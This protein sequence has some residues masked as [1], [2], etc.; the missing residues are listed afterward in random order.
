MPSPDTN[1]FPRLER[2]SSLRI[3]AALGWAEIGGN[4]RRSLL[5]IFSISLGIASVVTMNSLMEGN[6]IEVAKSLAQMG[7]LDIV[8]V[9]ANQARTVDQEL[10][11]SK[12]PGLRYTDL[13]ALQDHDP[14]IEMLLPEE[15]SSV[16]EIRGPK[17]VHQAWAA[18]VN[19]GQFTYFG[20]NFRTVGTREGTALRWERGA[21]ICLLGEQLASEIFGN[22]EAALG[23]VLEHDGMKLKVEGLIRP[24]GRFDW[25]GQVCYFPYA[26]Q[27][28]RSPAALANLSEIK[29]KL[30][31]GA[32]LKG[33]V[34]GIRKHLLRQHR[35]IEDFSVRTAEEQIGAAQKS[36]R[37]IKIVGNVIASLSL[38]V[39]A[40]GILNLMLAT[41]SSRLRELGVRKAL[42][43]GNLNILAQFISESVSITTMGTVA[44]LAL[45]A[46][47]TLLPDHWLPV[48]PVLSMGDCA[49]SAAIGALTGFLAGIYPAVK[50]ARYSPVEA[51][52]NG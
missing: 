52:Q 49:L 19:W 15:W 13:T 31:P 12:S 38:G 2:I 22:P 47:P 42:G 17:G 10:E 7:G 14:N 20:L 30:R 26:L 40:I 36:N 39:G 43:A 18:A 16:E 29:V 37:T 3:G 51:L 11:Y 21:F 9:S 33:A 46:V 41:I 25:R 48:T 28:K 34:A 23:S 8:T 24:A 6:R 4:L 32:D 27:M 44:G 50:A 35:G 1:R 5:S 45:G